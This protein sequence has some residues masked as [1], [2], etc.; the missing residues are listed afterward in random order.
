M[1]TEMD[2]LVDKLLL[3]EKNNRTMTAEKEKMKARI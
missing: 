2:K 3:I 1:N